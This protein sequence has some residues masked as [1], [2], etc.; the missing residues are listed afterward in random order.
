M[1]ATQQPGFST[2][3]SLLINLSV[4]VVWMWIA[5]LIISL[6]INQC[7]KRL[8]LWNDTY[9]IIGPLLGMCWFLNC[10][11]TSFSIN[12]LTGEF[13]IKARV[14]VFKKS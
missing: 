13:I 6:R 14:H 10:V 8:P 4:G 5:S 9:Q 7:P 11:H 3:L 1:V 12:P 2:P